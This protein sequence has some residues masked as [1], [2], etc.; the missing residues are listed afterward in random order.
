MSSLR[1]ENLETTVQGFSVKSEGKRAD[2][3]MKTNGRLSALCFVEIKKHTTNLIETVEKPYRSGVW[4]LSTEVT[5]A[6]SQCHLTVQAA[7]DR[8]RTKLQLRDSHGAPTGEELFL[9]Q[10][11][12]FLVVGSLDEFMTDHGP[13]ETKYRSFEL[14]RRS[15][16]TPE[17][18]TFDELLERARATVELNADTL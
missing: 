2:A 13:N 17:I 11:R 15:L 16:T 7:M 3:L 10:P 14:L 8:F 1:G 18:V 12:T 6:I 5:G 9:Y 4:R